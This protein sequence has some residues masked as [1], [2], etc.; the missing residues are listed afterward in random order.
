MRPPLILAY[1]V[2]GDVARKHDPHNLAVSADAFRAQVASLRARGYSFVSMAELGRRLPDAR[3][4]C[5]LT[6]DDGADDEL[7]GLLR[8]LG[9]PGTL[10]VCP[11]LLGVPHPFLAPAA[12]VRLLTGEEI[13]A[14]G[15][16]GEIE[17]GSHT[18]LHTALDAAGAEQARLEMT[19]SKRA[20]EALAGMEV[21]SFAY[22]N[23]GYSPAC[24]AAARAAG[25]ATAVTCGPRGSLAPFELR[26][27]TVDALEN[28]LTWALKSRDL[29][30]LAWSSPPGRLARAAARPVRHRQ[31][32]E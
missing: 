1:H 27:V 14:L 29:W 26:R 3:G 6:F 5:A 2:I 31:A 13:T 17:L 25:Y 11:G 20:L 30:R 9:V 16:R 23:C 10:Y 32:S 22:P 8:E 4:L 28:R 7:P 24:P 19:E 12:G 18:L 21:T 15:A